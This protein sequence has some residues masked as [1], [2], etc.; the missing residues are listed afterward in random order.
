MT[1]SIWTNT[2][3]PEPALTLLREGTAAHRLIE[4]SDLDSD[5]ANEALREADI[6]FGQPDAGI[7]MGSTRL[8]WAHISSAGYTNYDRDDFKAALQKRGALMSNSSSVFDEPCAQHL[9][10]MMLADAR[11]LLPS[12]RSQ[13]G[14]HAWNGQAGRDGSFLLN[15]RSVLILGY[16]AIARRLVQLLSPFEM[17]ISA[18]RRHKRGDEGI[19]IIGEDDLER[20]FAG[21]DHVINILPDNA[22]T[23]GWMNAER[24]AQ[25]KPGAR[26]YNIGRGAT[27]D[28]DA[29][30][31]ALEGGTLELAYLD[32]T[33]PEPLPPDHPLW[34]APRCFLTPHTAGG[35]Q[36]EERRLVEHFLSNLRSL[37]AGEPL[38]DRVV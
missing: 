19:E 8:K 37:E 17:N 12:Y 30:S 31:R 11:Q 29:L 14:D 16:G 22:S 33:E 28:Q 9:L 6:A 3:L 21:A 7:L 4:A 38:A 25:M 18:L 20:A 35:F 13:L 34:S 2:R 24:F 1:L 5:E 27:V 36:G 26:F 10:A 23:R 15:G 32:V